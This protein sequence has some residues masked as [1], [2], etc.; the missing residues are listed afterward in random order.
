MSRAGLRPTPVIERNALSWRHSWWVLASGLLEPVFYLLGMG[1]GLGGL[2]GAIELEGRLV[3]YSTFVAAGLLASSA[4]NG[5][6]FDSTFN[7]FY[8]LKHSRT[9]DSMLYSPLS[10]RDVLAGEVLW[11]VARGGIYALGFLLV[12]VMFGA[13][14]S[15]WAVLSVPAALLIALVFAALGSFFT[16]FVRSWADFDLMQLAILPMFMCSTTFFP[17]SVYPEWVQPVVQATPLYNGVAL[18]RDLHTGFVGVHDIGHVLYLLV[19]GVIFAWLTTGR[20]RKLF[21]S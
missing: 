2:V 14:D 7:F 9:F 11:A 21:F 17:L 6:V 3:T 4:M 1:L 15:W 5:A 13:V 12:T 8:K 16:T 18:I 19:V 20:M 10:M